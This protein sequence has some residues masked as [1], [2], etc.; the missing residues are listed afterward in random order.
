M[1]KK[2]LASVLAVA[3]VLQSFVAIMMIS[4]N[5]E[6]KAT[7]K[8]VAVPISEKENPDAQEIF[9]SEKLSNFTAGFDYTPGEDTEVKLSYDYDSTLKKTLYS[10]DFENYTGS[11]STAPLAGHGTALSV[12]AWSRLELYRTDEDF[13]ATAF[14]CLKN[15]DNGQMVFRLKDGNLRLILTGNNSQS[16]RKLQLKND[17]NLLVEYDLLAHQSDGVPQIFDSGCYFKIIINGLDLSVFLSKD[18]EFTDSE[19]VI[20]VTLPEE[21]GDKANVLDFWQGNTGLYV[22]DIT[23]KSLTESGYDTVKKITKIYKETWSEDFENLSNPISG[24]SVADG[25]GGKWFNMT[26]GGL[27]GDW[28]PATSTFGDTNGNYIADFFLKTGNS[29]WDSVDI[30]VRDNLKLC[31][32]GSKNSGEGKYAAKLI[33]GSETIETTTD[34]STPLNGTYIRIEYNGGNVAVY[35]ETSGDFSEALP[36]L[37]A[38]VEGLGNTGKLI[39]NKTNVPTYIDDI[40]VYNYDNPTIIEEETSTG[41]YGLVV[42]KDKELS[43]NSVNGKTVTAI[44]SKNLSL[45]NGKTYKVAVMRDRGKMTVYIDGKSVLEAEVP[46]DEN[47][48][49]GELMLENKGNSVKNV[50]IYDSGRIKF[51]GEDAVLIPFELADNITALAVSNSNNSLKYSDGKI[52]LS[53][54][55]K[56]PDGTE[57]KNGTVCTS[58][59]L[60]EDVADFSI[61]FTPK[62]GRNDWITDEFFFAVPG[63]VVAKKGVTYQWDPWA[64]YQTG[65]S[66]RMLVQGAGVAWSRMSS[67][68]NGSYAII[69]NKGSSGN[70]PHWAGAN[71]RVRIVRKADKIRVYIITNGVPTLIEEATDSTYMLGNIYWYHMLDTASVS[72]IVVYDTE[73]YT[74]LKQYDDAYYKTAYNSYIDDAQDALAYIAPGDR[75][76]AEAIADIKQYIAQA[77]AKTPTKENY[78]QLR[79]TFEAFLNSGNPLFSFNLVTDV[80]NADLSGVIENSNS[81]LVSLGDMTLYGTSLEW[82]LLQKALNTREDL[83][84][85]LGLGTGELTGRYSR[86][87]YEDTFASYSNVLKN[88]GLNNNGKPYYSLDIEGYHFAVLGSEKKSG[89]IYSSEQLNWLEADLAAVSGDKPIFV[90]SHATLFDTTLGTEIYNRLCGILEKYKNRVICLTGGLEN[91]DV[92]FMNI[93]VPAYDSGFGY[94]VEVYGDSVVFRAKD[95]IENVSQPFDD[96][97]LNRTA[98]GFKFVERAAAAEKSAELIAYYNPQKTDKQIS[99]TEPAESY[100]KSIWYVIKT[101]ANT[102][103]Y[104]TESLTGDRNVSNMDMTFKYGASGHWLTNEFYFASSDRYGTSS[105]VL[106][107]RGDGTK[108]LAANKCKAEL[109]LKYKG[110]EYLLDTLEDVPALTWDGVYNIHVNINNGKVKVEI[111]GKNQSADKAYVMEGDTG[112]KVLKGGVYMYAYNDSSVT[113]SDIIIYNGA[114]ISNAAKPDTSA[115]KKTLADFDFSDGRSPV[116]LW[117][118]EKTGVTIEVKESTEKLHFNTNHNNYMQIGGFTGDEWLEDFT[119]EFNYL[120]HRGDWNITRI[121]WHPTRKNGDLYNGVWLAI[122]GNNVSGNV[123]SAFNYAKEKGANIQLISSSYGKLKTLGTAKISEINEGREYR[124]RITVDGAKITVWAWPANEDMPS[125]PLFTAVEDD[126]KLCYGDIWVHAWCSNF[127]LDDIKIVNYP[128][129]TIPTPT[130]LLGRAIGEI[131]R[132]DRIYEKSIVIDAEPDSVEPIE[133]ITKKSF[134]WLAVI[135]PASAVLVAGGT[136]LIVLVVKRRKKGEEVKKV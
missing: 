118:S 74:A 29:D 111:Y 17:N 95:F 99:V 54:S 122:L 116:G 4:A 121:G 63:D 61:E 59:W 42:I 70:A 98:D 85:V 82:N 92:S 126:P 88:L 128:D 44:K 39:V 10:E 77:A 75:F 123:D 62:T 108:D 55:Y 47:N 91:T 15:Y 66:T 28:I 58:A 33:N 78:E 86:S 6:Q 106:R 8:A 114:D 26:T 52:S 71:A 97:L 3:L 18:T 40:T 49:F 31:F 131:M 93:G 87:K 124:F 72:N 80:E 69:S 20:N 120:G 53:A 130:S 107:I 76:T 115:A 84:Y 101:P 102:A 65:Y 117:K 100:T 35:S 14:I 7:E 51:E 60:K 64:L 1:N 46:F 81:A 96:L 109:L 30:T 56:N 89:E 50:V 125:E 48:F 105:V 11:F 45:E 25:H 103:A 94:T 16:P 79:E 113:L 129:Y 127:S 73:N 24:G 136:V 27:S 5:A 68:S 2:I 32:R 112:R 38:E 22:D 21:C 132:V 104:L 135:I 67:L 19:C 41:N 83:P 43:I 12:G 119:A 37:T 34:F 9:G 13:S 110:A 57:H 90:V 23:V 133:P 134:P 36:I